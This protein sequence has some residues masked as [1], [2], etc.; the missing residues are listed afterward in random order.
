MINSLVRCNCLPN[1]IPPWIEI[2]FV[3]ENDPP[4]WIISIFFRIFRNYKSSIE[5]HAEICFVAFFRICRNLAKITNW[6]N[7]SEFMFLTW[8]ISFKNVSK[9]TKCQCVHS[10]PRREI[11]FSPKNISRRGVLWTNLHFV[12]FEKNLN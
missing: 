9:F 12:N 5:H 8:S 2:L 7:I 10:E 1:V 4:S 3:H 6:K 11:F